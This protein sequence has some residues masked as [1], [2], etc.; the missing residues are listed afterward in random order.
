MSVARTVGTSRLDERPFG[1]ALLWLVFLGTLFFTSYIWALEVTSRRAHVP[2]IVFEWE[3]QIPFV[4]WTIAPYW[5]MDLF[6]GLSLLLCRNRLELGV[7][8]RRLLTAQLIAI[9]IFIFFP[10][11]LAWTAPAT[12][13][14][15]GLLFGALD[16]A[17]GRPYNLAPSLHIA[18][19]TILWPFYA[20]HVPRFALAPLHLWFALI[21]VSV[22][23]TF[24]HHIFDVPTGA[25]LGFFCLWVW[26]E[27]GGSPFANAALA[28]DPKRWRL[29]AIYFAGAC[30][31]AA[32]AIALWG[33]WLLLLWPAVSLLVVA[34]A[35]AFL[36]ATAFQKDAEGRMSLAARAL[37]W[38]YLLG[39]R[40]NARAW[41]HGLPASTEICDGVRLGSMPRRNFRQ[42]VVD[43]TAELPGRETANW[44]AF[45]TLDLVAPEP[46][47]LARAAAA[48]ERERLRGDGVLVC[49]ALGVSR[50]AA[51]VA[52]WL[53]GTGRATCFELA[54][55][56]I[57]AA[58][59]QVK[60]RRD[61]QVAII[62]AARLMK[63]VE[64]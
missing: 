2:T 56:R 63:S 10:L 61:C 12:D 27:A 49:C 20:R 8:A 53:I 24:Q 46:A 52:A 32:L 13:G 37:L 11:R 17:V 45:A 36:G 1:R 7:H 51:A 57:V 9:P 30:V 28:S 44:L 33:P 59:P 16:Q 6:Y 21:G 34:A 42:P 22:L 26:P 41:T 19:L 15:P 18:L 3:R 4:P 38:P 64:P 50:S 54:S 23:T 48:I 55:A 60:L 47:L 14:L 5:S 58:R 31:C 39:A 40:L 25:L 62:E 29:A 43:L 35:Y